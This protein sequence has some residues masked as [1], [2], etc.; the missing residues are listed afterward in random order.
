MAIPTVT[1]VEEFKED[2]DDAEAL[3]NDVGYVDTRLG[4]SKPT[5][6]ELF[7]RAT[8]GT[9]TAYSAATT[10]TEIDEWVTE[11]GIVYRPNPASLP[12]GP[13]SFDASN[14]AVVQFP[15]RV[16]ASFLEADAETFNY[17]EYGQLVFLED[18]YGG[19]FWRY[20]ET[21]YVVDGQAS[22]EITFEDERNIELSGGYLVFDDVLNAGLLAQL[23]SKNYATLM[24][25][26]YSRD[27]TFNIN[28]YGDSITYGQALP[29]TSGATNRIGDPTGFGDGGSHSQWQFNDP[30]P[31]VLESE[32]NKY[33]DTACTVANRG[34]SGARC[35]SGYL[36]HQTPDDAGISLI[37]YGV[38]E[39][40]FATTNGTVAN[41]LRISVLDGPVAYKQAIKRFAIREILRGNTVVLMSCLNFASA[42]GWDGTIASSTKSMK[43]YD[44]QLKAVSIE[45]GL[46]Y[47]DFKAEI[48]NSYATNR[49]CQDGVHPNAVGHEIIGSK[50]ASLF[51]TGH[52]KVTKVRSGD[53]IIANQA[54]SNVAQKNSVVTLS[55]AGSYTPPF[56]G[57]NTV[58]V[59]VTSSA[60]LVFAFYAD[61]DDLIVWPEMVVN[62]TTAT[63]KL[64]NGVEQS[65][66]LLDGAIGK[67]VGVN[68]AAPAAVTASPDSSKAI[69]ESGSVRHGQAT[70]SVLD[71]DNGFIHIA[72]KGYYTLSIENSGAS[73]L[74]V[75]GLSFLSYAE[76]VNKVA[77]ALAVFDGD[78]SV[79]EQKYVGVSS[80]TRVDAGRYDIFFTHPAPDAFYHV[81][82]IAMAPTLGSGVR[83]HVGI[84]A[85]DLADVTTT[86]CR[87]EVINTADG[88]RT[89]AES[90]RVF[91]DF[92]VR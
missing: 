84:P 83:L 1:E 19:S 54:I 14:W 86:K 72:T 74:L 92:G 80:V 87:I 24:A 2:I 18:K 23:E 38:N 71:S 63:I 66:Y 48:T 15:N 11:S 45:L 60:P 20:L 29:S 76:A 62:A 88:A 13:E 46:L 82:G 52:K 81:S 57:S 51:L 34:Y 75:D 67:T 3:V 91:F 58:T 49:I 78:G 31:S 61:Q 70:D 10:Y 16:V 22:T 27:I 25:K 68:S 17:S 32:L 55:N 33:F 64:S 5:L 35:Y 50:L 37:M 65:E 69:V 4:G 9:I 30:W 79:T 53:K 39:T 28:C 7:S 41:G 77:T 40:L 44:E 47:V 21:S 26:M 73:G 85:G 43:A 12:I 90:V 6:T 42:T 59:A 8:S 89:D 56:L 36:A